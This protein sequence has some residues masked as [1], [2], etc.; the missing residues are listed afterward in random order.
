MRRR[1]CRLEHGIELHAHK[2]ALII[3]VLGVSGMD[4]FAAYDDMRRSRVK[5]LIFQKAQHFFA[6]VHV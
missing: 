6:S 2:S 4:A 1:L 3:K 5:V